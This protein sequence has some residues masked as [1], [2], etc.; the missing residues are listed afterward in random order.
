MIDRAAPTTAVVADEVWHITRVWPGDPT[1]LEARL[2]DEV[3]GGRLRS[4]GTVELLDPDDDAKLPALGALAHRGEL[5]SHRPGKRAV[6]RLDETFAKAVRR[7][8]AGGVADAHERGAAAFGH[9]FAVPEIAARQG[10]AI[11][12]TIV[13]GRTLDALGAD[14][15]TPDG[16][17]RAAWRSW[18]EAWTSSVAG[19]ELDGLAPHTVGDEARILREWADHAALRIG[20]GSAQLLR[21]AAERLIQGLERAVP[22][23]ERIAHRDLH[24][25]QLLWDDDRGIGLIDLDTCAR[26]DPAL[27][28][29]NLLAHAELAESQGRWTPDRARAAAAEIASAADELGVDA[30]SVEAWRRAARFRIACVHVLRPPGREAAHR[31]LFRMMVEDSRNA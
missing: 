16:A 13:P 6:V 23:P 14:P 22:N 21:E 17:W 25:K 10:D 11:E 8:R 20:A 18:R 26:A 12:L 29:G 24:D 2:G 19:G 30:D 28:L 4:D 9:A 7:G 5:V 27:D 31:D 3:R 1:P 15:A